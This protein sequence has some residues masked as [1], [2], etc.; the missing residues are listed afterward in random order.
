MPDDLSHLPY[1]LEAGDEIP[2]NKSPNPTF[3][4]IAQARLGRRGMLM[5][6]LGAAIAGFIGAGAR[7]KHAEE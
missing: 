6:G 4:E 1:D 7:P 2:S 3:A 5:G